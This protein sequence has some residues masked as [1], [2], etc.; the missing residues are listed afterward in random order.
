M[1]EIETLEGRL[2]DG[3]RTNR[4][5]EKVSCPISVLSDAL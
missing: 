1:S 5:M 2:V 4:M 3:R